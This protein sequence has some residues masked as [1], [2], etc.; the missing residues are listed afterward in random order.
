[1]NNPMD[2][3]VKMASYLPFDMIDC[4]GH[5]AQDASIL[6]FTRHANIAKHVLEA[7]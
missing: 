7:L 3:V 1:M 2:V 4:Q 5:L 6:S